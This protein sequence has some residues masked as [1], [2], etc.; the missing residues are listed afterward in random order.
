MNITTE[1]PLLRARRVVDRHGVCNGDT[2]LFGNFTRGGGPT[3]K[4]GIYVGNVSE[5]VE[6]RGV[7][8]VV[9]GHWSTLS[10]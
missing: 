1:T 10:M 4:A 7:S 2:R 8:S 9:D 5:E 6:T 3:R